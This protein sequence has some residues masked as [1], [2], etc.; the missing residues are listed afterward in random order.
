MTNQ[1]PPQ[2]KWTAYIVT[3]YDGPFGPK[4]TVISRHK[5]ISAAEQTLK[6]KYPGDTANWVCIEYQV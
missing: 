4:G 1:Q 2:T 5:S 3:A 6:N